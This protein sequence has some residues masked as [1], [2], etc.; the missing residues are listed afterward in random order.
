MTWAAWLLMPLGR[1]VS[2]RSEP[3]RNPRVLPGIPPWDDIVRTKR[4][5]HFGFFDV[6]D[7]LR[8]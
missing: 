3:P 7:L 1:S 6:R 2:G 4:T 8:C 5:W